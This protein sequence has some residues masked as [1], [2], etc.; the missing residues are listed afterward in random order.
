MYIEQNSCSRVANVTRNIFVFAKIGQGQ[1]CFF[2][3]FRELIVNELSLSIT[4]V[5]TEGRNLII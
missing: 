4:R 1:V 3:V 2:A 5:T